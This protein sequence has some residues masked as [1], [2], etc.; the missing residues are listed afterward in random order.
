MTLDACYSVTGE[1]RDMTLEA[2][3]S[4]TGETRDMIIDIRRMLQCNNRDQG[5]DT[6]NMSVQNVRFDN[7]QIQVD[8]Q[9]ADSE[10]ERLIKEVRQGYLQIT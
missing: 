3:Y 4:V 8:K 2:C 1:T 6:R 10:W 5:H 9:M 7:R